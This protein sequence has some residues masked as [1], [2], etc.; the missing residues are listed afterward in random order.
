MRLAQPVRRPVEAIGAGEQLL[1][2]LKLR[3]GVGIVGIAAAEE[4][5]AVVGVCLEL[6]LGCVEVLL[7]VAEARVGFGLEVGRDVGLLEAH[8]P[9][10]PNRQYSRLAVK[11]SI[12]YSGI[13]A[14]T[15]QLFGLLQRSL[16]FADGSFPGFARRF[17]D[18]VQLL[19]Q[20][21]LYQLQ[22]CFIATEALGACVRIDEVRHVAITGRQSLM[23][24]AVI[25]QWRL[26]AVR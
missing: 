26:C 1:A 20:V 13:Q 18:L 4:L 8:L 22:F 9:N 19:V 12:H 15:Y 24:F 17:F 11:R 21:G 14:P 7:K 16:C 10:L 2:L 3:V 6:A 25:S 5:A 23:C